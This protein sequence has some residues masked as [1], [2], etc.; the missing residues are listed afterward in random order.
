MN[1]VRGRKKSS[2]TKH[3]FIDKEFVEE[4]TH[5]KVIGGKRKGF[6]SGGGGKKQEPIGYRYEGLRDVSVS[7]YL[8]EH[9]FQCKP[10][11]VYRWLAYDNCTFYGV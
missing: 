10:D 9:G 1:K 4:V 7:K 11:T 6:A 8:R 3:V 5:L 2:S